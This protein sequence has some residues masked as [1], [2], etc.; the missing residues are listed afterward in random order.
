MSIKTADG[1]RDDNSDELLDSYSWAFGYDFVKDLWDCSSEKLKQFIIRQLRGFNSHDMDIFNANVIAPIRQYL[2]SGCTEDDIVNM[3]EFDFRNYKYFNG[4]LQEFHEFCTINEITFDMPDYV[5]E[6]ALK[7]KYTKV[8]TCANLSR[9]NLEYADFVP[10]WAKKY[11][12]IIQ[13]FKALGGISRNVLKHV[14]ARRALAKIAKEDLRLLS[15]SGDV[16]I[17]LLL[18]CSDNECISRYG[19]NTLCTITGVTISLPYEDRWIPSYEWKLIRG[20]LT[21]GNYSYSIKKVGCLVNLVATD[22]GVGLPALVEPN[23]DTD[24]PM[25][26]YITEFNKLYGTK[27]IFTEKCYDSGM[28]SAMQMVM[29]G[30]TNW[31]FYLKLFPIMKNL[32]VEYGIT[33]PRAILNNFSKLSIHEDERLD[34]AVVRINDEEKPVVMAYLD[35]SL[36][37]AEETGEQVDVWN[38]NKKCSSIRDIAGIS[39]VIDWLRNKQEQLR[40]E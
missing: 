3:S 27:L 17:R 1:F 37:K 38:Q 19:I 20:K 40:S 2:H 34:I 29:W 18:G 6:T 4:S 21:V 33:L 22:G 8:E 32:K 28:F 10:T 24:Y 31:L 7:S 30:Q 5:R 36:K 15:G 23:L 9:L 16:F 39:N 26:E 25:I 12:E 13:Y 14:W 11:E 35:G